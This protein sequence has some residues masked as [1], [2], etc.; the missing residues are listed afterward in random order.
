MQ[1][2]QCL[3]IEY[4]L[5]RHTV[6]DPNDHSF[7]WF[8]RLGNQLH[9]LTKEQTINTELNAFPICEISDDS[10]YEV[11]RHLRG[12]RY[13]RDAKVT[14]QQGNQVL[15]ETWD[16]WSL[17]PI[18]EFSRSAGENE[19]T[20]GIKD[21]NLGGYGVDAELVYFDDYQRSGYELKLKAPLYGWDNYYGRMALADTEDGD[22]MLLELSK[23]FLGSLSQQ[24]MLA[25]AELDDRID[26]I[27]Q[28]DQ[29]VNRFRHQLERYQA[30]YG[31][32][33]VLWRHHSRRFQLGFTHERHRFT[34]DNGSTALLPQD[35]QLDL[36]WAGVRWHQD[37]FQR[38]QNL[39]LINTTEDVNLGWTAQLRLGWSFSDNEQ[40]E[41]AEFSFDKGTELSESLLWLTQ[42]QWRDQPNATEQSHFASFTNELFYSLGES[43]RWY[44]KWAS[45]WSDN[46]PLDTPNALGGFTGLRGYPAEYQH[47]DSVNLLTTELRYYPGIDIWQLAEVAGTVFYDIGRASGGSDYPNN[48]AGV[49]QS[50]GVGLRFYISH[51]GR[52]VLHLDFARP[53][54]DNDNVNEWEWRAVARRRF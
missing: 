41:Y 21:S 8:H 10:L 47:G 19:F 24:A 16:T 32:A 6:F 15:V 44:G 27:D 28:N 9:F 2:S 26:A 49:L 13:F 54:S 34:N 18:I 4:Q 45:R 38:R 46:L 11:E 1:L 35:R 53:I 23:P 40:G 14:A 17:L 3:P 20:A 36:L 7:S 33:P 42:F 43:W 37:R 51:G 39:F 30:W 22:R 5:K 12:K 50:V 29:E 52:N 48:P 31:W 25:G